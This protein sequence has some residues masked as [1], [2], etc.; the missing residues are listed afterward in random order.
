MKVPDFQ[1]NN[2]NKSKEDDI[3]NHKLI[4]IDE[5]S[6]KNKFNK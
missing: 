3:K 2:R 4:S 6:N 5:Q 1:K